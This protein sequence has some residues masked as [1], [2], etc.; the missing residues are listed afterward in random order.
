MFAKLY[1]PSIVPV[2]NFEYQS[3]VLLAC[4]LLLIP[5]LSQLTIFDISGKLI[6]L[7]T[8]WNAVSLPYSLETLPAGIYIAILSS[9]NAHNRTTIFLRRLQ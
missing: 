4:S 6:L 9:V 5:P 7:K 1:C 8:N 2:M 3:E